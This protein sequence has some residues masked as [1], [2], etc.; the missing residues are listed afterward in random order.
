MS[1]YIVFGAGNFGRQM[2]D[3][4]QME[5]IT[6]FIDN[7]IEKQK[8]EFEGFPVYALK[9]ALIKRTDEQIVLAVSEKYID[10]L[11]IQLKEQGIYQYRTYREV[12]VE[13]IREKLKKRTDYLL[14]YKKAVQWIKKN[15]I[16]GEGIINSTNIKK[17]Y[18]E[19]T[20]YFIPTLIRW[21]YKDLA[22]S[23]AKWLC[24]IQKKDG[25]WFDTYD[26][27]PYIFD[28]AQI[29]KGLLAVR[30]LYPKV[31]DAI[32]RGCD[33]ILQQMTDEGQLVTPTKDAWGD[34]TRTCSELIHI[35][36]L[37]PL[38][39]AGNVFNRT[40][41]QEKAYKIF[42]YYKKNYYNEIMNFSLLSHFYAYVM[43]ALLDMG[44]IQMVEEAM[45]KMEQFQKENGAVPAYHNV[46]WVCSTGLFQLALVW[47]R[48]G[49]MDNGQ[50]AFEYACKLQNETGGWFGSYL[51]EEHADEINTYIPNAEISWAVKYFLDALYYKNVALFERQAPLFL[52]KI[53]KQDGRYTLI[54]SLVEEEITTR[55]KKLS[56]LD[57]GCGKGR[58]L[59]NLIKDI[60]DVQ[61]AGVDLSLKVMEFFNNPNIE[62]RQGT[63][64]NIPYEDDSFDMVYTC[65][66]L[67]H[68]VDIENA[69]KEMARVTQNGGKIVVIDKNKEKLGLMEIEEWE[70]WFSETELKEEML[71]YCSNVE[72]N[73]EINSEH[74]GAEG[75]FYAWIGTIKKG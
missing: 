37:S 49:N 64:T 28:S 71:K 9:D 29:L 16:P 27:A 32:L 21:G 62:K 4:L 66:A 68:A 65:E 8:S 33:W 19:V 22:V 25:S 23:Y 63:L 56:V 7:S 74:K 3:L 26:E 59:K 51:S 72:V 18:P 30:E 52:E 31:D 36:C 61:Y 11:I 67:E 38:V 14:I 35:Y 44:E 70:Q 10:E 42:D 17:S 60:P 13:C 41:Y 53:D 20:G 48:L 75:L 34:D 45:K 2:I 58:Y 47:F 69:I 39:E 50:K 6:F 12:Q 54:R 43:E 15:S 1:K 57:I 24:S 46:E 73:K 5:N 55:N 40:D